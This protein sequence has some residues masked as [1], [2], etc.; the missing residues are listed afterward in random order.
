MPDRSAPRFPKGPLLRDIRE[1]HDPMVKQETGRRLANARVVFADHELLQADFPELAQ[2]TLLHEFPELKAL[3][4]DAQTK[5][6]HE[7]IEAWLVHNAAIVSNQ[8]LEPNSVNTAIPATRE[9]V[10]VFRPPRYGR[11][12]LVPLPGGG[13]LDIK[14]AGIGVGGKP[15]TQVHRSGLMFLGEAIG[16]L[17]FQQII[18][19]IFRHCGARYWTLPTYAVLAL[20]FDMFT[21]DRKSMPAGMQVRRAHRRPPFGGDLPIRG[22]LEQRAKFEI[23]MIL[24]HFGLTSCNSSTEITRIVDG[25]QVRYAYG[26][27]PVDVFGPDEL[28]AIHPHVGDQYSRFE[29]VNVQLIRDLGRDPLSAQVVDFGHF[30]LRQRFELPVVSLVADRVMRWGGVLAPGDP[31]YVQPNPDLALAWAQWG[32]WTR[33]SANDVEPLPGT[34]RHT[35]V[36]RL[37]FELAAKFVAGE[38]DSATLWAHLDAVLDQASARWGAAPA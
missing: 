34:I 14:G 32:G 12:L 27:V 33:S 30:E 16:D 19:R 38:L 5:A 10:K 9:R 13:L 3:E 11:A 18:D 4:G 31:H 25:D 1:L 35:Q 20:G 15:S 28:A 23:E 36:D 29:G 17:A 22:T 21:G 26:G 24:R 8:Q 6:I 7:H 37:A 2:A